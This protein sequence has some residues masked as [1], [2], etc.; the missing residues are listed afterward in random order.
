MS[1]QRI[2][3]SKNKS[4]E[5]IKYVWDSIT[6]SI[7]VNQKCQTEFITRE[8]MRD[9]DNSLDIQKEIDLLE[10][11]IEDSQNQVELNQS[12]EI[13]IF[14]TLCD[15]TYNNKKEINIH[16]EI[17]DKNTLEILPLIENFKD[18][19]FLSWWTAISLILWHRKSIDLDIF[20]NWNPLS[21]WEIESILKQSKFRESIRKDSK[22][23]YLFSNER[24]DFSLNNVDVTLFDSSQNLNPHI[25]TYIPVEN[26]CKEFPLSFPN[27]KTLG[28]TKLLAMMFR[29][30]NKDLYD[31]FLIHKSWISIQCMLEET[32][33][34]YWQT[35]NIWNL[36]E[37]TEYKFKNEKDLDIYEKIDWLI[38]NP[39]SFWVIKKFIQEDLKKEILKF[40][41]NNFDK[42]NNIYTWWY[43]K[44]DSFLSNIG[45]KFN[46][47][48]K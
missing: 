21:Q 5:I 1:K 25:F 35:V 46:F 26:T 20:S 42:Y 37:L 24:C 6:F 47:F 14:K 12:K 10:S 4:I 2:F 9:I 38:P 40:V 13:N 7:Y 3:L 28:A 19:Y 32:Y 30:K 11:I 8:R 22:W 31:I 16:K 23:H 41:W 36:L 33:K 44:W 17:L 27:L 15:K 18:N 48:K 43:E 34:I 29:T 45:Y 39:P